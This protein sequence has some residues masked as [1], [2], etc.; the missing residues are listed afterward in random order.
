M[1][2]KITAVQLFLAVWMGSIAFSSPGYSQEMLE[3]KI[4]LQIENKKIGQALKTI[5]KISGASFMYSPELIR[6]ERSVSVHAENE[7]L[8]AVLHQLLDPLDI[9]FEAH[10]N[11][12]LLKRKKM[13][14]NESFL[15]SYSNLPGRSLFAESR[16]S[17]RVLDEKGDPLPGV[18]ILI[19]GTSRGVTTDIRGGF[20]LV[21]PSESSI[22]IFSF[23]GY[24]SQEVAA[25]SRTNL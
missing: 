17:G 24:L 25:G 5:G 20:E 10:Q 12:I 7:S 11:Q 15:Q 2:M 1:A 23:V 13:A 21:V 8:N 9:S 6:S 22:L 19:K 14:Q 18:N 3:K 16:V 4:T